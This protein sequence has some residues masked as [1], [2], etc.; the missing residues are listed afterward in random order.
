MA[1]YMYKMFCK[2]IVVIL[3][4]LLCFSACKEETGPYTD[5][6]QFPRISAQDATVLESEGTLVANVSG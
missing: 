5:L 1:V 6:V 3:F 2:N 4:A